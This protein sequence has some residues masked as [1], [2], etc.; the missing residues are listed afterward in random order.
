ATGS[1]STSGHRASHND[2]WPGGLAGHQ[3]AS[4]MNGVIEPIR[5]LPTHSGLVNRKEQWNFGA[6][7]PLDAV[8]VPA[9]RPA[10]NLDQAITL[11]RASHCALLILCSHQTKAAEVH[12][13]LADR[14]FDD[15]IVVDLP[16]GYGHEMFDFHAL[17]S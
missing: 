1:S 14:S 3:A 17:T 11:A 15:A 4:E 5:Q 16:A 9:S 13:L 10:W 2:H 6:S 7:L 8:I 12:E